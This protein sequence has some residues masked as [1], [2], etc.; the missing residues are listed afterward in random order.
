LPALLVSWR[1]MTYER[2]HFNPKIRQDLS[3]RRLYYFLASRA[4]SVIM[5]GALFCA[6]LVKLFHS[7]RYDSVSEYIGWILADIS[8]LL[9]VEVILAL[10]CFRWPKKWILRTATIIAAIV[11]TWS[12]MNAGWLIRTGTQI[13]PSVLLP[14]IRAPLHTLCIIGVNLI[15]MPRAAIILLGPSAVALTFSAESLFLSLLLLLVLW[16]VVQYPEAALRK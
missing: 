7:L 13:L 6:L 1:A 4:Y 2:S 3:I 10:V 12:V 8:F 9:L 15:K 16:P 11:C 5:L 14:L